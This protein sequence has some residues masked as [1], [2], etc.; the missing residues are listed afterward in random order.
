MTGS[1]GGGASAGTSGGGA[2]SAGSGGDG[3]GGT[4]CSGTAAS[5][6]GALVTSGVSC[7]AGASGAVGTGARSIITAGGAERSGNAGRRPCQHRR[8]HCAMR[9]DGERGGPGPDRGAP[10]G[11]PVLPRQRKRRGAHCP[12]STGVSGSASPPSS[13]TSATLR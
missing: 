12:A 1:G 3:A 7:V 8:H 2:S 9:D 5:I 10:A 11:R 6:S 4:I 13:A